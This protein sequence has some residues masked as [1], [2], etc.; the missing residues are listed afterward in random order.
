MLAQLE[1]K[2]SRTI[3]FTN[4]LVLQENEEDKENGNEGLRPADVLVDALGGTIVDVVYRCALC[5]GD[6]CCSGDDLGE[7]NAEEKKDDEDDEYEE[8]INCG[9]NIL[10]PGF[11]DLQLNGAFGVDFSDPN[12][13]LSDVQVLAGKLT[14][15][16]VTSFCP[17]LVS[18]STD[19][20]RRILTAVGPICKG[21]KASLDPT[22]DGRSKKKFDADEKTE[23]DVVGANV[24]GFHLEGPFFAPSKRGAHALQ[25]IQ[26]PSQGLSSVHE[27]YGTGSSNEALTKSGVAIVTLAP[28]IDG[29]IEAIQGL[30]DEG[31][32]VAIGHTDADL[33][34]GKQGLEAGATLITHLFNAMRGFH[35]RNPG[36][37]GLLVPPADSGCVSTPVATTGSVG[38]E[39]PSSELC[40]E[41]PYYSVIADGI[42]SDPLSLRLARTLH[43][44]GAILITDAMSA[45]GLEDGIHTLGT[46]TVSVR[47]KKATI[48][49]SDTLAGSV[50]SMDE[51]VKSYRK[52]TGCTTAEA[53]RAATLRPAKVL[54]CEDQMGR[55]KLG[56]RADL[57]LLHGD[58]LNVLGTWVRGRKAFGMVGNA[59]GQQRCDDHAVHSEKKREMQTSSIRPNISGKR[60]KLEQ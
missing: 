29:A 30:K 19:T 40:D 14:K 4:C 58:S 45:M 41:R 20:Y 46:E 48:T 21:Y 44:T 15:F 52:C 36:L 17:T 57:V 55:I 53:L 43:P 54:G 50:M 42:H 8:V 3:K 35:H 10:S 24:L 32:V 13:T 23:E 6:A 16:G 18:C 47:G 27:T 51:C 60:R 26:P 11:I 59:C 12:I 9:G 56:L 31:A 1:S 25:H 49:G 2:T 34:Q 33:T 37:L 28:E 38:Y 7:S 5:D 22:G 39:N